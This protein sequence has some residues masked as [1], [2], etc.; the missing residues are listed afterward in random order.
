MMKTLTLTISGAAAIVALGAAPL[1]FAQAKPP[2]AAKAPAAAVPA[3]AAPTIT[4]NVPGICVLSR[5]GI[6]GGSKVGKF[7]QTRLGQLTTQVN[8]ELTGEKTS[9]ETAA[10]DLDAKKA[11]LG[12]AAY[13]QQGSALQQRADALQQKAQ[14]RDRE[15]QATE[16]KALQHVLQDATPFVEQQVEAKKCGVVLDAN[17]ILA[18]NKA[19]DLTPGVIAS[20]DTKEQEFTF[21]REHLDGQVAPQQR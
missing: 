1:A 21:D 19:M 17:S 10:K 15:L 20:L 8:A 4:A 11:T 2:V 16:Q 5:E 9:I 18:A 14:Q 3:A 6:I 13:Q 12:Q 7:V